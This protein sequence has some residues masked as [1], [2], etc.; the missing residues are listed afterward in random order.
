MPLSI[1]C[2]IWCCTG[3]IMSLY[4]MDCVTCSWVKSPLY[5]LLDFG[6]VDLRWW[7]DKIL[8]HHL[9]AVCLNPLSGDNGFRTEFLLDQSTTRRHCL[10]TLVP[11]PHQSED[12]LNFEIKFHSIILLFYYYCYYYYYIIILLLISEHIFPPPVKNVYNG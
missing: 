7:L 8:S 9:K 2:T 3:W 6:C 12:I 10:L 11:H 4:E 1:P 5:S